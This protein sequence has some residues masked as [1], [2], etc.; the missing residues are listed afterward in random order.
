MNYITF[1]QQQR[2]RQYGLW[3]NIDRR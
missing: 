3:Y 1:K 2:E